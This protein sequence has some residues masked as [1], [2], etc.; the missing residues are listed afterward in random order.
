MMQILLCLLS[1]KYMV[2]IDLFAGAGGMSL[3]AIQA[4]IEVR[5]AIEADPHAGETY[6]H[7]HP[8]TKVIVDDIKNIK[9]IDI[10]SNGSSKI[11]FGGP[12]C[13]GFSTSNQR[14]R[15]TSNPERDFLKTTS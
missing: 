9:K 8:H 7:N 13:R 11:L 10:S 6:A 12:P 15:N 2:G 14:T 5:I 3:G 4:G 1:G